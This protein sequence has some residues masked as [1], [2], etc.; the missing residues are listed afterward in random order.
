MS[1]KFGIDRLCVQ[2]SIMRTAIYFIYIAFNYIQNIIFKSK[3]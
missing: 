2:L 3:I 1:I